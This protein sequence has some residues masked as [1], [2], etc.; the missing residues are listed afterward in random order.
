MSSSPHKGQGNTTPIVP[1]D[2]CPLNS[3]A[4]DELNDCERAFV[5]R[6]LSLAD[7]A[8][9]CWKGTDK[10]V[11]YAYSIVPNLKR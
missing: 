5:G 11:A 10:K 6:Y 1:L 9:A 2:P 7:T 8:L 4:S 3:E